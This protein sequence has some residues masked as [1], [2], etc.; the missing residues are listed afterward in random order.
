MSDSCS[1]AAEGTIMGYLCA[2]L[3]TLARAM[4]CVTLC[5]GDGDLAARYCNSVGGKCVGECF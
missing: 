3:F 1:L 2:V 4:M 5:L